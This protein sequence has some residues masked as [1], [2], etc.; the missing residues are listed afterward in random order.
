MNLRPMPAN[1]RVVTI[2]FAIGAAGACHTLPHAIS[3]DEVRETRTLQASRERVWDA[4]NAALV[5]RGDRPESQRFQDRWLIRTGYIRVEIRAEAD[6]TTRLDVIVEKYIG[7]DYE[8]RVV[9]IADDIVRRA[10][11]N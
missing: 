11:T 10:G 1:L 2:L 8:Q 5:G 4:A 3:S 7:T 9:D 6:G